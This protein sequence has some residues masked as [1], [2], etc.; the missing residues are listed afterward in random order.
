MSPSPPNVLYVTVDSLRADSVG[1]G[2]GGRD[3]TPTLDGLADDGVSFQ[4]AIANG[5][6]TYYSF[7]SLLG[8]V[9]SLSH[10]RRIGLP[11]TATALAEAFRDA[12]Y[13]TAGFNAKNPW[14]T[15]S[16]G[17]DRG[18]EVYRDF[19]SDSE[20]SGTGGLSRRLK[21]FA[22]R[23]VAFSE[24]LTD[25]LGQVGRMANAMVGSQPLLPAEQ[26]TDTVLNW[27]AAHDGDRPFFVWVHYMDP[28]YPW[29]PPEEHLSDEMDSTPSRLDIGRIWHTVAHEYKK[30]DAE[31]DDHTVAR[32]RQ[33]YDAEV[34]RTDAAIGRLVSE[35]K[36]RDEFEETV[37]SVVGDHG[38]ELHD[39]GGFS[40]GPDTLYQEVIHVPLLLSGYGIENASGNLAALVDV[41]RT[42]IAA[43]D[44]AV[45]TPETFEGI[46]LLEE[47]RTGVS[48][49]VVYDFDPARRQNSE[50]D[51]LQA[52]TEPPWKLI[53]NRHTGSTELYNIEDDPS[54]STPLRDGGERWETLER[55]LD[56]HRDS[57]ERRNR[58]ITEKE[59]VREQI[60]ELREAGEL[61]YDG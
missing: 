20:R 47:T 7:K 53:R 41:P 49:E 35:L 45:S 1:V 27:L 39:H 22:K 51:L 33:L 57:V 54:E 43:T 59:R 50:N 30:A 9:H 38:T 16:Y 8:G 31:I 2:G 4:Y 15:R 55:A 10:G 42:L 18:F 46:N 5:I 32:I 13:S 34:R 23:S 60:A 56:S 37:M 61:V 17:Y 21:R 19:V 52:R 12:G 58:T 40:H 29:I 25:T 11:D 26:L 44:G 48:T 6:P 14:L 28:H 24:T 36:N 3:T